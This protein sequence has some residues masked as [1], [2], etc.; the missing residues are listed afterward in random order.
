MNEE[1]SNTIEI[2]E[3]E[4]V[5]TVEK[6]VPT[7]QEL[8]DS[9]WSANELDAA[10]KRGMLSKP[11]EKKKVQSEVAL[12]EKEEKTDEG[13]K[14]ETDLDA[15]NHD[16]R[17]SDLPDFTF[18]TPEQ[19]K[20]FL[21]AFGEG[22]PQRGLYLR[23]KS[24]RRERQKAQD[25]AN[26]VKLEAQLLKDRIAELEKGK[27]AAEVDEEGNEI[28]PDD[29]PLTAKMLREMKEKEEQEQKRK[30]DEI[31]TQGQKVADALRDQEEFAKSANPDYEETVKLATDLV[32]N[33]DTIYAGD[34]KMQ[35]RIVKL[36]RDLQV[37]SANADKL[38]LDDFNAA[39]ISY[40]IG[41]LH[42]SYGKSKQNGHSTDDGKLK[43][44]KANGSLTPE[45]MKRIEA[46]TQRR[47]SSASIP[48]GGRRTVSVEDMT[49]KDLL[50]LTREQRDKF[51][52]EHPEK[53]AELLRG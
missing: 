23:M 2:I 32:Q 3:P 19:E 12:E 45:Q 10:E 50:K 21:D 43:D 51:R 15:K 4:Q 11:D 8:K 36:F 39:D 33:L 46:N 17:K 22:T 5:K 31:R 28:D 42:P 49:V 20:A 25:E 18:K 38:T 24:E 9:G 16:R 37:A 13:K 7:R 44:P 40:E 35:N 14:Q 34:T 53:M 30:E 29:K 48:G 1:K 47:T 27:P 52:K 6:K 41:K 26:R